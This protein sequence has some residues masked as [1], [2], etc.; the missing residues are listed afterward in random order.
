MTITR[1]DF[2]SASGLVASASLLGSVRA[3]PLPR[4]VDVVVVGGGAAGIAAARRVIA[5]GQKAVILEAAAELGG[6]CVTDAT[7]FEIPFDRGARWIHNPDISPMAKLARGAGVELLAAPLGRKIRIGRRNARAGEAEE[8]LAALVRTNRALDEAARGRIDVSCA[9]ALPKDLGDWTATTEFVLGAN[10][11]GKDLKDFSVIDKVRGQERNASP[12]ACRQGLGTLVTRL[13]ASLPVM[14]STPVSR[15]VWSGRDVQVETASGRLSARAAIVTVSTNMLVAGSI[16]FAPD[17]PRRQLDAA[18]A[19]SLGSQD[20]IALHMTGNPLGLGRDEVVVEQSSDRQTG[21]LLANVG[22]SALC[23]VDVGGSFGRDLSAQGEAAMVAFAMEWLTRLYG[24]DVAGA[25]KKSA[26]TRWDEMP[27]VRGAMS[28]APPGGQP[29]RRIL[30]EPLGA[31]FL[32]G[33]ASHETMWG[34]VDGAW[35]SGER[36]ADAALRK[37]GVLRDSDNSAPAASSRRRATPPR[38]NRAGGPVQ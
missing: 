3:A 14:L 32:T 34:T 13:G 24:S 33:E 28:C 20:R 35:E 19:L 17:L 25:V 2:L 37:L 1:R 36:A 12:L 4:E 27:F 23:V 26:A 31:L 9:S 7:S 29:S 18:A 5:A 11:A 21:S 30:A 16:K 6:R 15:I 8:F 22:G 10:A 38:S